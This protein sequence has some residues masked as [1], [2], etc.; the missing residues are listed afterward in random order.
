MRGAGWRAGDHQE[1]CRLPLAAAHY[2]HVT[3]TRGCICRGGD[4]GAERT[5]LK[6][7]F[8]SQVGASTPRENARVAAAMRGGA[9]ALLARPDGQRWREPEACEL[10]YRVRS[11]KMSGLVL[12]SVG[13]ASMTDAVE[14]PFRGR[15]WEI[16]EA[17]GAAAR[18]RA[19]SPYLATHRSNERVSQV[20]WDGIAEP[21]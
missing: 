7:A 11:S 21:F 20:Y 5:R 3:A 10:S 16:L 12:S 18:K 1:A 15:P 8:A 14:K 19:K 2:R 17:T 4:W 6:K 13:R 9:D